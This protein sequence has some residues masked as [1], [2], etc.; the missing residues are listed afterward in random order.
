MLYPR[1][2]VEASLDNACCA[3]CSTFPSALQA[4]GTAI[5]Q[6]A[7]AGGSQATAFAQAVAYAVSSG[8]CSGPIVQAR[9]F[10]GWCLCLGTCIGHSIQLA[11]HL[12]VYIACVYHLFGCLES[13]DEVSPHPHTLQSPLPRPRRQPRA[14]PLHW[15][16]PSPR[17]PRVQLPAESR[18]SSM[19]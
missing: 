8:G 7:A 1:A 17:L 12:A 10:A 2:A 6:A 9:E 14:L 18:L 11:S 4:S 15:L 19:I 3:L 16:R 13:V 5:A